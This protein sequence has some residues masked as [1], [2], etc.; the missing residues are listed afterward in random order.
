MKN[1]SLNV[2]AM[3]VYTISE[4]FIVY[5]IEIVSKQPFLFAF[6]RCVQSLHS[7]LKPGFE[8]SAIFVGA[9]LQPVFCNP[10][11]GIDKVPRQ[12]PS[13]VRYRYMA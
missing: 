8:T 11:Q 4:G 2:A 7:L 12:T 6:D 13:G 9:A 10:L 3:I 5:G 1:K